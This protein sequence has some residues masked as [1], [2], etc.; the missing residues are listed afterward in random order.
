MHNENPTGDPLVPLSPCPLVLFLVGYRG[1]GKTT[2]ARVL[3]ERLGWD[4]CDADGV[5]EAR[6]GQT[7]RR[8][9]ADE[10]EAGFRARESAVL[11]D[12]CTR[13]RNV[14]ATGGGVIQ[15]AA[16]RERLR[17]TGFV[18]WLTADPATI[19]QRLQADATTWERRPTLTVGGLAEIEE[20]LRQREPLYR[21][22]ADCTVDTSARTPDE[23]AA[24]ILDCWK[25][26]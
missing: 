13:R 8:I 12:L 21:E 6:Y 7:I 3:A 10:G 5:L 2:T 4:W 25:R 16:N 18:A 19:W 17:Q 20:L 26:D 11:E 1:T 22:V 9:F 23:V 24:L 15:S 14:I